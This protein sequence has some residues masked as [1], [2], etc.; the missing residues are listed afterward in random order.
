MINP[1]PAKTSPKGRIRADKRVTA[2][3]SVAERVGAKES[4]RSGL[5]G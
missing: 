3:P 2:G 1:S 5:D 4:G